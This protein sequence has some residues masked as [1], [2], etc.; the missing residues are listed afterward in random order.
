MKITN[1]I[2]SLMLSVQVAATSVFAVPAS[3]QKRPNPVSGVTVPLDSKDKKSIDAK[4]IA[5]KT[6]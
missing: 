4:T 2:I 1:K 3:L 5:K 6:V